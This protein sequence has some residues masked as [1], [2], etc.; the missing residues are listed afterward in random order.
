MIATTLSLKLN[1][2]DKNHVSM[3]PFATLSGL[4]RLV[5]FIIA[6]C[7]CSISVFAL[8]SSTD[9]Y[10]NNKAKPYIERFKAL[11]LQEMLQNNIPASIKLAQGMFESHYGESKLAR[12]ANN[13]FGIKCNTDWQGDSITH[14]DDAPNECFRKYDSAEASYMDHSNFILNRARYDRLFALA[15]NDYIGWAKGLKEAGYATLSDYAER[16]I[17]LIE[18]HNLYEYDRMILENRQP[19][20]AGNSINIPQDGR[21]GS[22]YAAKHKRMDI[23]EAASFVASARG[24][25]KAKKEK[26]RTD[27]NTLDAVVA[28]CETCR[29]AAVVRQSLDGRPAVYP[30]AED[31]APTLKRGANRKRDNNHKTAKKNKAY[32]HKNDSN[33]PEWADKPMPDNRQ[34]EQTLLKTDADLARTY[35]D[36]YPYATPQNLLPDYPATIEPANIDAGNKQTPPTTPNE[37]EQDNAMLLVSNKPTTMNAQEMAAFFRKETKMLPPQNFHYVNAVKSVVYPYEVSIAQI[38]ATYKVAAELLL[39]Y[40]DLADENSPFGAR[41]PIFLQPKKDKADDLKQHLAKKGETLWSIAQRYAINL[42]ALCK[43]NNL[44]KNKSLKEGEKIKLK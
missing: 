21:N 3:W 34:V 39:H 22:I 19:V 25:L 30:Q 11:A 36:N 37:P 20:I 4:H 15:P 12:K 29:P 28:A 27:L 35:T 14:T 32:E 26:E 40:N 43:I 10:S 18:Q 41:T 1:S 9:N 38:S 44:D 33:E 24:S 13:H 16:I 5:F 31:I 42:D 2:S 23:G 17:D 8:E 6:F 7:C